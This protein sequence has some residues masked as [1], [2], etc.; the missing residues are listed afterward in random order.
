MRRPFAIWA[1]GIGSLVALDV[2]LDQTHSGATLSECTRLI[3]RTDTPLGRCAFVASWLA[4]STWL[5]PHICKR[6]EGS[7]ST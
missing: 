2:A 1:A 4:L 6:V 3:Y 7:L 5:V